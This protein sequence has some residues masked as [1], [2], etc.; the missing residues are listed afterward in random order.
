MVQK[1]FYLVK[2]N[3]TWYVRFRDPITKTIL[4]WKSTGL[5]NKTAAENW[6]HKQLVKSG[7]I[8]E[9]PDGK[10]AEPSQTLGEWAAPFYGPNCPYVSRKLLDDKVV[11]STQH[12]KVYRSYVLRH[13]LTDEIAD[14]PLVKIRRDD[15]LEWRKRLVAKVGA[16]RTAEALVS[17]MKVIL[18]EAAYREL[19]PYAPSD[20]VALPAYVKK[21]RSAIDLDALSRMLMP[22]QFANPQ[23]WLATVIAATTEMRVSEIRA[24]EWT[25]VDFERNLIFVGQAFKDQSIRLGL[26]KNG[27]ARVVPMPRTL[28]K[29][30]K[31]WDKHEWKKHERSRFVLA[32]SENRSLGYK[33]LNEAVKKAAAAAGCGYATMHYL[34]HTLNTFLRNDEQSDTKLQATFGWSGPGI[35]GNYSHAESYDYS[36]QA[37]A[38]DRLIKIGNPTDKKLIGDTNETD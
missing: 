24:L 28:S 32:R 16:S 33:R 1:K 23:H 30:L 27:K 37:A 11:M 14:K 17:V 13:I 4:G 35:Q 15:I 25:S 38:I 3:A 6:C 21:P 20:K 34:R 12:V 5:T 9:P 19:I 36:E 29:L 18:N 7:Q 26:P 10:Q 8:E 2:R 22:Q 31:E